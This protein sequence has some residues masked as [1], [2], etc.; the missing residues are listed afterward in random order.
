[1]RTFQLSL[2]LALAGF[3]SGTDLSGTWIG[4]WERQSEIQGACLYL[5][6][7][8]KGVE[9]QIA[10]RHDTRVSSINARLPVGDT[11]EF[12]IADPDEGIVK[13]RLSA[14]ETLS[15][16]TVLAG[17]ASAGGQSESITLEKYTVPSIYY[18]YGNGRM[19]PVPIRR[20]MPEYTPQARAAKLQGTVAMWVSI[21]SSG[22]VGSDVKVLSGLGLGLDEE[23]VKCAKKWKFSPPHYDCNANPVHVRI[24]IQFRLPPK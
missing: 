14:S 8:D 15:A 1:M 7:G 3:M 24:D 6:Q 2:A 5:S 10:Y 22:A 4:T 17:A 19:D 18:R 20:S 12:A 13:L 16:G 11:V 21:E 23:A 9:G